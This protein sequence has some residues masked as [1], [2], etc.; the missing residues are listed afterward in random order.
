MNDS[1]EILYHEAMHGDNSNK[2][3]HDLHFVTAYYY[4]HIYDIVEPFLSMVDHPSFSNWVDYLSEHH[5]KERKKTP[6][7]IKKRRVIIRRVFRAAKE[8]RIIYRI[9]DLVLTKVM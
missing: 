6:R 7:E 8:N 1:F 5:V 2:Y 3:E 9:L 4:K